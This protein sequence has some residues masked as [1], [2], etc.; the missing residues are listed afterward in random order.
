MLEKCRDN[1]F[2]G[3]LHGTKKALNGPYH[4]NPYRPYRFLSLSPHFSFNMGIKQ[5]IGSLK[6]AL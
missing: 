3:F 6:H 4:L 2:S 1:A 5:K